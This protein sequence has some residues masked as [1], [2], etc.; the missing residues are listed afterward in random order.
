MNG[1]IGTK[2]TTVIALS[3]INKQEFGIMGHS[4]PKKSYAQ[5]A[6]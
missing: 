2:Q 4:M 6:K 3:K 5:V 1:E